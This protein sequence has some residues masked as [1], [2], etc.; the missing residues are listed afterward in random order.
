MQRVKRD[1]LLKKLGGRT[2]IL[3]HYTHPEKDVQILLHRLKLEL[4]SV[5]P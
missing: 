4:V 3:S 5:T 2:V 1:E